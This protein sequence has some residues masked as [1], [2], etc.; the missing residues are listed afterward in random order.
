MER[1][2]AAE[3][4]SH[5]RSRGKT[6]GT[7][8]TCGAMLQN[9]LLCRAGTDDDEPPETAE[10]AEEAVFDP[11]T[12]EEVEAEQDFVWTSELMISFR[13]ELEKLVVLDYLMRNT[14][15]GL[16]NFMIKCLETSLGTKQMRIGAIDNSLSFPHQH[17]N[18]I[19]DYPY[20]WLWLPVDLIGAPF[21]KETRDHFVPIL[22][23]PVWWQATIKGLRKLFEQ[24]E[25]FGAKKFER[26]MALL[27]GQG[28]NLVQSLLTPSDGECASGWSTMSFSEARTDAACVPNSPPMHARRPAR[29]L[30]AP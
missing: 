12:A 17:P 16:D 28:W 6:R 25:H 4:R 20:G 27:K 2:F 21:S 8:R 30:R 19:R 10:E 7:L 5:G 14:D 18:G 26:Q 23:D 24:D 3:R 29:A 11:H 13:L 22:S 1:D 9:L 15:R